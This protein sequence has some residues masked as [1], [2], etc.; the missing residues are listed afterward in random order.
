MVTATSQRCDSIEKISFDQYAT[1]FLDI[2]G[3]KEF[4][5][6]VERS[7][8]EEFHAF[9]ELQVVIGKQLEFISDDGQEQHLFPADVQ[10]TLLHISDSF[11]LSAPMSPG[12]RPGYSGLVAV[13]IKAIQLA[14]Q[15]LR[16]GFLLR[17]GIAVG[18]VYRTTNNIFGTGYQDAFET[19]SK[20]A[21]MPRVLLHKSA[22]AA[23]EGG[24]HSGFPMRL[25]S[26]F[27]KEAD[28]Y[29][30]D[31]LN[32]HWSY[33]GDNRDCDVLG[34]FNAY[35]MKIEKAL[36]ELPAGEPREKWK[37]MA[38][39]FEAKCQSS[40]DLRSIVPIRTNKSGFIF[41]QNDNQNT[42]FKEAFVPFIRP[43]KRYVINGH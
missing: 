21:R 37:W 38:D 9:C 19:E 34:I 24:V 32:S 42:I 43:S 39:L 23:L 15:L 8:S 22:V 13:A 16:M 20:L 5:Q 31:T 33:I 35:K 29:I 28:D 11:V 4:M 27:M 36:L 7:G 30:L 1:A 25:L 14:H 40:N 17:G 18:P 12:G 26:I 10:L 6:K 41:G 3:F 2:L